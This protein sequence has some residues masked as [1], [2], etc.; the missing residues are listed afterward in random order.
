MQDLTTVKDGQKISALICMTDIIGFSQISQSQNME[1]LYKFLK[2]FASITFK[3]I[4]RTAGKIIKYI[5]DSSLII[6]PDD[7]VDEGVQVLLELK[8]ELEGYFKKNGFTNKITFCLHFGEVI[9]GRFPP[10]D[11][12]DVLGDTVNIAFMLDRGHYRGG[13]VITPQVFRKLKPATRKQ[14]HKFTPPVVYL[15]G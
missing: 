15:A 9:A 3:K 8:D 7:S 1:I 4:E 10:F 12:I 11:S 13:F 5:G 2:D 6:F 14:F